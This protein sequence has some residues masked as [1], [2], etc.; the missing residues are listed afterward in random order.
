[1]KQMDTIR[2]NEWIPTEFDLENMPRVAP[3][4]PTASAEVAGLVYMLDG[5]QDGYVKSHFY[6]CEKDNQTGLYYWKDLHVGRFS[7][8]NCKNIRLNLFDDGESLRLIMAWEDPDDVI[9]GSEITHWKKTVLVHQVGHMP[10]TVTD[11]TVVCTC[12]SRNAYATFGAFSMT[13]SDT[14]SRKHYFKLFPYSDDDA[15]T[16]DDQNGRVA[17][18][19]YVI[20]GDVHPYTL[21]SDSNPVYRDYYS[22]TLNPSTGLYEYTLL[23]YTDANFT[24]GTDGNWEFVKGRAYYAYQ[25][26]LLNWAGIKELV[27]NG[28][29]EDYFPCGTILTLPYHGDYGDMA[30]E[31]VDFDNVEPYDANIKFTMTL[32]SKYLYSW[33]DH[34]GVGYVFDTNEKAGAVTADKYR[35]RTKTYFVGLSANN[36]LGAA[37]QAQEGTTYPRVYVESIFVQDHLNEN[38]D[39]TSDNK[40]LDTEHK[41]TWDNTRTSMFECELPY[42]SPYGLYLKGKGNVTYGSLRDGVASNGTPVVPPSSCPFKAITYGSNEITDDGWESVNGQTA[43]YG[44]GYFQMSASSGL[45]PFSPGITYEA[46]ISNANAYKSVL[47]VSRLQASYGTHQWLQTNTATGSFNNNDVWPSLAYKAMGGLQLSE[48]TE[49]FAPRANTY[50][51][52]FAIIYPYKTNDNNSNNRRTW[53]PAVKYYIPVETCIAMGHGVA[54]SKRVLVYD[55]EVFVRDVTRDLTRISTFFENAGFIDTSAQPA[56]YRA[57]AVDYLFGRTATN[58]WTL[59]LEKVGQ[60]I[61]KFPTFDLR[62]LP[63]KKYWKLEYQKVGTD[64]TMAADGRESTNNAA[65]FLTSDTVFLSY[66]EY[67][68]LSGSSFSVNNTVVAGETVTANTYYERCSRTTLDDTAFYYRKSTQSGKDYF[69]RVAPEA[70]TAS[71]NSGV[72]FYKGVFVEMVEG[73]DYTIGQLIPSINNIPFYA[74]QK[75]KNKDS[76]TYADSLWT[77]GDVDS[78]GDYVE[79]TGVPAGNNVTTQT[80]SALEEV[81]RTASG[82][83]EYHWLSEINERSQTTTPTNGQPIGPCRITNVYQAAI[84]S[85]GQLVADNSQAYGFSAAGVTEYTS[86]SPNTAKFV[87]GNVYHA[88]TT[89]GCIIPL[90]LTTSTQTAWQPKVGNTFASFITTYSSTH[91]YTKIVEGKAGFC[92]LMWK[93]PNT[94]RVAYGNHV[95]CQSNVR[96]YLNGPFDTSKE[97]VETAD[98]NFVSSRNYYKYVS[99]TGYVRL[100]EAAASTGVDAGHWYKDQPISTWCNTYNNKQPIYVKL[101][102]GIPV[103]VKL[104]LNQPAKYWDYGASPLMQYSYN[105]QSKQWEEVYTPGDN[106]WDPQPSVNNGLTYDKLAGMYYNVC[107]AKGAIDD[108]TIVYKSA[109]ANP[110]NPTDL[111]KTPTENA[112]WAQA[113]GLSLLPH[114]NNKSGA[115]AL[116]RTRHRQCRQSFLHGFIDCQYKRSSDIVFDMEKTYYKRNIYGR[117]EAVSVDQAAAANINPYKC[118]LYEENPTFK[119]DLQDAYDFLNAIVPVVNR[120]GLYGTTGAWD[121]YPRAGAG[122]PNYGGTLCVDKVWLMSTNQIAGGTSVNNSVY[123]EWSG[124]NNGRWNTFGVAD[125]NRYGFTNQAGHKYALKKWAICVNNYGVFGGASLN[126]TRIKYSLTLGQHLANGFSDSTVADQYWWLRSAGGVQQQAS[127]PVHACVGLCYINGAKRWG[128]D[129]GYYSNVSNPSNTIDEWLSPLITIG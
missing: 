79:F 97:Y 47:D 60:D 107:I 17:G 22:R 95:W 9:V 76:A 30:F 85:S 63:N 68:T 105:E 56:Q 78:N 49:S 129:G 66:K 23:A 35:D 44:V 1:M 67:Y 51:D 27:K 121:M 25:N 104:D 94:E 39:T 75:G 45:D 6:K 52:R 54:S 89:T 29:A 12:E 72:A 84:G 128:N 40:S 36:S 42:V 3:K 50:A 16:N 26:C 119:T 64:I 33:W 91:G 31:V 96:S 20:T 37:I 127:M 120:N 118:G 15:I 18:Y 92:W 53:S 41:T 111:Y 126:D 61:L 90:T 13:L 115:T 69:Y 82:S 57:R 11:G 14:G 100:V 59:N 123:E 110:N 19:N 5:A 103:G 58:T 125:E 77:L 34:Y 106:W 4:L 38:R 80:M 122:A 98:V 65:Y 87:S 71:A 109:A 21:D 108:P 93:M 28:V 101:D 7:V 81:I 74:Q 112:T 117:Y 99:G 124:A 55:R 70:V 46:T 83:N 102:G 88:V 73:V 114:D 116:Y 43:K 8:G 113:E 32:E 86:A 24:L 62:Y 2:N 10:I 48:F